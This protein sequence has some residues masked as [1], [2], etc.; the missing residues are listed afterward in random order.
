MKNI[1]PNRSVFYDI[2]LRVYDVDNHVRSMA[3]RKCADVGPFAFKIVEKHK[4]LKRGFQEHVPY[5]KNVFKNYLIPKWLTTFDGNY[6]NFV[7][8]LKLNA[9][10]SDMEQFKF[11]ST[12]LIKE[13]LR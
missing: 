5:V 13:F 11:I 4:I 8:S 6:L 12:H 7:K 9:D 3:F 10:E 1:A 2:Q